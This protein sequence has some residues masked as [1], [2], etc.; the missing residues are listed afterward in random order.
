MSLKI[1]KSGEAEASLLQVA[2]QSIQ[3]RLQKIP[4]N[5]LFWAGLFIVILLP[6][7]PRLILGTD[8]YITVHDTLDSEF[9]WRMKM[10]QNGRL[11][12]DSALDQSVMNGFPSYLYP[13]QLNILALLFLFLSPFV[14]YTINELLVHSIAFIG[15]FLLLRKYVVPNPEYKLIVIG[16]A[17]CFGLLPFYSI[18]N[19]SVAGQPLLL[20]TY[21]NLLKRKYSLPDFLIIL[22]FP[23]F[24]SLPLVGFF[25][26]VALGMWFLI[27]LYKQKKIPFP[28]LGGIGLLAVCYLITEHNLIYTM[29]FNKDFAS[30]REAYDPA[31]RAFNT[32][33]T[34]KNI[35]IDFVS[36]MIHVGS[37]HRPVLFSV[38]IAAAILTYF[39]KDKV[40]GRLYLLL[41]V[42]FLLACIFG[43]YQWDG[44]ITLKE[45]ISFIKTFNISRFFWFQPLVW[46]T[47]FA[48]SLA[49]ILK[50]TRLGLVVVIGLLSTQLAF[51]IKSTTFADNQIFNNW[52]LVWA[53]AT[54]SNRPENVLTYRE[55]FS[56]PLFNQVKAR[57][58]KPQHQYRVVSFGLHASIAQYNGFYTLDSYQNNYP[59]AYKKQ[60]REVIAPELE[61]NEKWR[62]YYDGWG[63]RAYLFPAELE[64][65]YTNTKDK[66]GKVKLLK[67]NTEAF[68]S[69]GGAYVISAVEVTDTTASG[70][71]LFNVFDH[72]ESPWRIYLYKVK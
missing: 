10:T 40:L 6:L 56:E 29:F 35:Y 72:P 18:Y 33:D 65:F 15:M 67:M 59:L 8:S 52:Y 53:E 11:I 58:G 71:S 42:C 30:H 50:Y 57:I 14:A 36:G 9:V 62:E 45:K 19:L 16:V 60:F 47:L 34:F 12:G 38:A 32:T 1:Q 24:S 20:Y 22:L 13:S 49:A 26:L 27:E 55:F 69:M 46:F 70:L 37:V 66:N 31:Y 23:F 48:F 54:G 61:R 51:C 39:R 68:K 64:S 43:I 3:I 5:Y 4:F 2:N 63:S 25:I 17:L 41:G 44:I 21:L 28:F 7:L